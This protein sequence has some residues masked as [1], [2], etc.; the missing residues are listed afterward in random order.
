MTVNATA[1]TRKTPRNFT[2]LGP[3]RVMVR[4]RTPYSGD[5]EINLNIVN[6]KSR[7]QAALSSRYRLRAITVV[8]RDVKSMAHNMLRECGRS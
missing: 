6:R 2:R 3:E 1:I 4:T 7:T 8:V 5:S